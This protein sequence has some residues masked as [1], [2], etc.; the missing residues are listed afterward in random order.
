MRT[1]DSWKVNGYTM[2]CNRK[3]KKYYFQIWMR[4]L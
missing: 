1:G 4:L 3:W 2:W